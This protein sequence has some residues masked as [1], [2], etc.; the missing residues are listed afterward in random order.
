M[1]LKIPNI[2]RPNHFINNLPGEYFITGRIY[3]E[4]SIINSNEKKHLFFEVLVNKCFESD[5]D[6]ITWFIGDDHYH[7]IV[8]SESNFDLQY[9]I[10]RVH[11]VTGL[12]F[13]K[14]DNVKGRK[15]WYQYWD[16]MIRD[17]LDFWQHVNYCHYNPVKHKYVIGINKLSEYEFCGF[18]LWNLVFG[19]EATEI[20]FETYPIDDFD[21]FKI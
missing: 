19:K 9:F 4:D 2:H 8:H 13:N 12:L 11:S 21:P 7:I 14:M 6:L 18:R 10:N 17:E 5:L 3:E 15:V 1:G 16:R 20:F